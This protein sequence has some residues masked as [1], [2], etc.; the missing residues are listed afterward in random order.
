MAIELNSIIEN[1]INY[2]TNMS[3]SIIKFSATDDE[4]NKLI[5]QETE[6]TTAGEEDDNRSVISAGKIFFLYTKINYKI[7]DKYFFININIIF[8][9]FLDR[10]S[11]LT[12]ETFSK[13]DLSNLNRYNNTNINKH[14]STFGNERKN[15]RFND[16]KKI[17]QKCKNAIDILREMQPLI[18]NVNSFYKQVCICNYN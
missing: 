15:Q 8:L 14:I 5:F 16:S 4:T 13:T 11:C 6:K 3:N 7:I 2:N 12:I 1:A 9:N 10:L 17:N 18:I